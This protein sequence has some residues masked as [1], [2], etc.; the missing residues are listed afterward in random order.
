MSLVF[1]LNIALPRASTWD[2]KTMIMPTSNSHSAT[3]SAWILVPSVL[4]HPDHNEDQNQQEQHQH[5]QY[6]QYQEQ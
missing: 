4:L 6:Q 2:G 1:C 3:G 5:Q